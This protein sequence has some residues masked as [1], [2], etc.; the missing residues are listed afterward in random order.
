MQELHAYFYLKAFPKAALARLGLEP[1]KTGH[2]P[3]PKP[4]RYVAFEIV[5]YVKDHRIVI[6]YRI[7]GSSS[8]S[9][10]PYHGVELRLWI[11]PLDAPGPANA[12]APGWQSYA[13]TAT[14]WEKTFKDA[15]DIGKRLYV[16]MRWEN[17]S[18]GDGGNED[19]GKGPWSAIQSIVIP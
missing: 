16:V 4:T 14:P 5:V 8:K 12:E 7:A 13:S 6:E 3:T 18:T 11:L 15:N 17:E 2:T 1:H 10:Y 19:D 9:K